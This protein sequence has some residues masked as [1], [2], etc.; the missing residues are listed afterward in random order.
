MKPGSHI[1]DVVRNLSPHK[2][3]VDT[4]RVLREINEIS[5]TVQSQIRHM[6]DAH[7]AQAMALTQ[8]IKS[9]REKTTFG[10]S[11]F[12][13]TQ[14]QASRMFQDAVASINKRHQKE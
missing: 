8:R 13:E 2:R 7:Q 6:A 12:E 1:W 10:T 4:G 9:Q 11:A 3:G 5:Q 14:E